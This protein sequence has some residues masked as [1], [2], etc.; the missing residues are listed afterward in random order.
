LIALIKQT[1]TIVRFRQSSGLYAVRKFIKELPKLIPLIFNSRLR[2]LI[3]E[4]FGEGYFVTKSIYF[5]KPPSANWFVAYH[6]DLTISVDRKIDLPGF[7]P[8]TVKH[9]QFAV[10]PPVLILENNFTIRIHL[11]NT[12]ENNG[13]LRIIPYSHLKGVYRADTIDWNV[14]KEVTCPVPRGGVMLMKPL[15]F[16]ASS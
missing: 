11:D 4:R 7:G 8:W 2:K 16:H 9:E 6:Q 10:Q 13:A 3:R 14:E 1:K 15:L 5:D 12:N